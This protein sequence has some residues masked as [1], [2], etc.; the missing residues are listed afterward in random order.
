MRQPGLDN[1]PCSPRVRGASWRR[2][3]RRVVL[4]SST[5]TGK[6]RSPSNIP[7]V[8]SAREKD[9]DGNYR[10]SEA[11]R[12]NLLGQYRLRVCRQWRRGN[13]KPLS[14]RSALTA[15][16]LAGFL[17]P[18]LLQ[19]RACPARAPWCYPSFSSFATPKSSNFMPC[20]PKLMCAR[21]LP[22]PPSMLTITPSPNF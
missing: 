5:T 21:A 8:R 9:D 20:R 15:V 18:L 16:W 22:P 12:N 4:E 2:T 14:R 17:F 19:P 13:I 10:L 6:Q 7:A 3:V 11:D 1:F